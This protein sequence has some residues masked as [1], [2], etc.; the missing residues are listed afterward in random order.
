MDNTQAD[1]TVKDRLAT[2]NSGK[3]RLKGYLGNRIDM[4]MKNSVTAQDM[5][6]LVRPFREKSEDGNGDW[7]IEYWGKWASGAALACEYL[8][9]PEY[10][11]KLKQAVEDIIA[12]QDSDGYIGTRKPEHH[13]NGWDVWGR[14]Y[15]LLG[16][17]AYYDI[18][19][20]KKVLEAACRHTDSLIA[21]LGPGKTNIAAIGYPLWKGLPPSSVL[22]PVALLYRRTGEKKYLDFAEHIVAQWSLPNHWSPNGLRLVEDAVAGKPAAEIGGA[23]KAYEMMSC[24]EGLCELYRATGNRKYFDASVKFGESIFRDELCIIGSASADELWCGSRKMQCGEKLLGMETCVTTTWIKF[25]FQL[26]KLTGE[27][28]YADALEVSLYNALLGAL[29]PDGQWWAYYTTLA[30]ERV[31]SHHQHKDAKTSCCVMNGP[32][33]M[34][35]THKWAVMSGEAGPVVNLYNSGWANL[36]LPSG[37]NALII[38]DTG[39]PV[40]DQVKIK[41]KL[42]TREEFILS[43]RIPAWSKNTIVKINS[44][45]A[46]VEVAAGTH[47]QLK[48][49]WNDGDVITIEFDMRGRIV[50]DPAG[51]NSIALM[52]GP[53][54]L[55][56][57]SRF[58]PHSDKT[59][60]TVDRAEDGSV[61]L[62][63]NPQTAQKHGLW[64]AF[65]VN[66]TTND[67]SKYILSLCDFASAGNM[68][69]EQ[70]LYRT[71]F[72]QPLD[73]SRLWE[74][75]HHWWEYTLP[76]KKRP[77]M[78]AIH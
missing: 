78:P 5:E 20:D 77:Q 51:G 31:A 9:S 37:R 25:C 2:I 35:L 3:V 16:L 19:G 40:D 1:I 50:N 64:M 65:D 15:V 55:A 57:D 30:G 27:S 26:L 44:E 8:L 6:R 34:L 17:L 21:E 67:K 73:F 63:Y 68:W 28:K 41:M 24:Y 22:E 59:V 75:I 18:S 62:N 71:W 4:L 38:Q 69:N 46:D 76:E 45:P 56:I 70:S 72:Q 47:L 33:G 43:L 60:L 36:P 23:P 12:T 10:L 66:F 39:Y 29:A 52:R 49:K 58:V 48:R 42:E 14:K 53:I 32:R 54:V 61:P 11:D 13:L 74:N 7:R